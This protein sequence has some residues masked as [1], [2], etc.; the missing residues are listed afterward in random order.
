MY[1]NSMGIRAIGRVKG[2][3]NSVVSSW[4]KKIGTITK[5]A[6]YEKMEEVQDKNISILELDELFTYVKKRQ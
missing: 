4:I 1:I 5:E 6:F 3:H 2:V